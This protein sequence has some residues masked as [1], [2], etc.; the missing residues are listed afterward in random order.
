VRRLAEAGSSWAILSNTKVPVGKKK[1]A[2]RR[3][4]VSTGKFL[5]KWRKKHPAKLGKSGPPH[6]QKRPQSI[7]RKRRGTI[8]ENGA[9]TR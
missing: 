3:M 6:S 1:T 5:E 7:V 8:G 2:E 9:E 4:V